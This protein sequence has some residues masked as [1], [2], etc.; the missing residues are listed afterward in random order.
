MAQGNEYSFLHVNK[1]EIDLKEDIDLYSEEVY[2]TGRENLDKFIKNQWIQQDSQ[3][4][5][6]IYAQEMDK[7]RQV[8]LVG[9]SSIVDYEKDIIK[10]HEKTI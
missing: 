6:Y 7:I 10:K 4:R 8:G 3:K 5:F 9:A 2:L 1:P